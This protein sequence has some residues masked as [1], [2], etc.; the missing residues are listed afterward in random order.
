VFIG[1]QPDGM[2]ETDSSY[3]S[4]GSDLDN[5]NNRTI[6]N[7]E[8][9]RI[10]LHVG[11]G[12]DDSSANFRK[13]GSVTT[14]GGSSTNGT[15]TQPLSIVTRDSILVG[16]DGVFI[17][18]D[19]RIKNNIQT[20]DDN[21]ALL[22]FRK[23]NPCTYSYVDKIKRGNSTVYG[24]IAQEVEEVLPYACDTQI[25]T[26]PNIYGIADVSGEYLILQ[27]NATFNDLDTDLKDSSGNNY[28]T[29]LQVYNDNNNFDVYVD[30]IINE[31]TLALKVPL[32][33]E[34]CMYDSSSNKYQIFIYGQK[35]NNFKALDKNAIWTVAAAATQEIDRQQQ[36]DKVRIAE[37]ET[38]VETLENQLV[39]VL[40]RL[41]TLENA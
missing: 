23:L 15:R 13:V 3:A 35:V 24:F 22:D 27:D 10:P 14:D 36:A 32:R 41:T 26:V 30:N 8:Y 16:G 1:R 12:F 38:K 9:D 17:Y 29:T 5:T 11:S 18:S 37:L 21:Q 39:S 40:Q 33:T 28:I 31:T 4:F 34:D 25:E 20:I 19:K 6:M 2:L 7:Y